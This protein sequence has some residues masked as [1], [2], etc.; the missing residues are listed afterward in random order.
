MVCFGFTFN[1]I[2]RGINRSGLCISGQSIR[3][4]TDR[5]KRY[6]EQSNMKI[7]VN[8]GSVDILHGSDLSDVCQGFK[9]LMREC[10]RRR[11]QPIITTLAPLANRLYCQEEVKKVRQFNEFLVNEFS[12]QFRVID[13]T[14]CLA[15]KKTGKL[16]FC[17]YQP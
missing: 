17:C 16:M 9:E 15:D 12:G 10:Q 4:A 7:I 14:S 5:I 11:I 2:G 3:D 13:I 1:P 6:P 8:L